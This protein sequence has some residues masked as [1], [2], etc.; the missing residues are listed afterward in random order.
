MAV[1]C[2]ASLPFLRFDSDPLDLK[3]PNAESMRALNDLRNDPDHSPNTIDVLTPN[4]AA[5]DAIVARMDKLPQVQYA[6]SLSSFLPTDQ[7][8]KLAAISDATCCSTRPSTR[9]T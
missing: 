2:V 5:A 4:L 1:A 8:P 6:V 3:N 9:L 7:A